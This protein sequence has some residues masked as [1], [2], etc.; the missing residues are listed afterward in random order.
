LKK[1]AAARSFCVE[2]EIAVATKKC[3]MCKD[4]Y[5]DSCYANMHRK[6]QRKNHTFEVIRNNK[7]NNPEADSYNNPHLWTEYYDHSAQAK[8]W[9]H[10][11]TGEAT[12][13]CPY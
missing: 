8:Y 4:R 3:R 9:Y 10:S 5:C 12:W 1:A 13:I 11:I 6:G 2:C 7:S